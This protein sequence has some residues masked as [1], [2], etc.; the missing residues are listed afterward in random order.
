[1]AGAVGVLA[2]EGGGESVLVGDVAAEHQVQA[3]GLLVREAMWDED[4]ELVG[5]VRVRAKQASKIDVTDG[6]P[7]RFGAELGSSAVTQLGD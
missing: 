1:M 4:S 7:L 2:G 6:R 5:R 3:I